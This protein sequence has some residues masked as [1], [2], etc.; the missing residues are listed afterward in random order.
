MSAYPTLGKSDRSS[1]TTFTINLS[2]EPLASLGC[3]VILS[4]DI[5]FSLL[6]LHL[7]FQECF[8]VLIIKVLHICIETIYCNSVFPFIISFNRILLE[9]CLCICLYKM[10]VIFCMSVS[11]SIL[12]NYPMIFKIEILLL[13]FSH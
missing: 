1:I 11:Y 5:D 8:I 9:G 3:V 2:P 6:I 7:F 4:K 12:L 13:L 10:P